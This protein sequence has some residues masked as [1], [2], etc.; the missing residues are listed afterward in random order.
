MSAKP[1]SRLGTCRQNGVCASVQQSVHV[2]AKERERKEPIKHMPIN[3]HNISS[4]SPGVCIFY[5][6]IFLFLQHMHL[7]SS[8]AIWEISLCIHRGPPTPLSC[9]LIRPHVSSEEK[10]SAEGDAPPKEQRESTERERQ[11]ER[12]LQA[13]SPL[14]HFERGDRGR[15]EWL[16]HPAPGSVETL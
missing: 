10:N 8:A 15:A 11:R 16:L 6:F 4:Y 3:Q 2:W 5:F 9:S 12:C 14:K 1:E 7:W 13:A